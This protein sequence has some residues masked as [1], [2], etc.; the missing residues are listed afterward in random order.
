MAGSDHR[1]NSSAF[2]ARLGSAA[3]NILASFWRNLVMYESWRFGFFFQAEDGIRDIGVTGVQT[4]ALPISATSAGSPNRPS[5]NSAAFVFRQSADS[6][7]TS[8]VLIGPGATALTRTP[9]ALT[10]R[11]SD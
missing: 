9:S 3:S 7:R 5:G 8:G 11:A 2:A 10:S 6:A 1:Q 4:C